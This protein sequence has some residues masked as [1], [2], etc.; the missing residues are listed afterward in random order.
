MRVGCTKVDVLRYEV[1][2]QDVP[3]CG[4]DVRRGRLRRCC[5]T[6]VWY[7]EERGKMGEVGGLNTH[8]CR[9][10][11]PSL[12]SPGVPKHQSCAARE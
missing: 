6:V 5:W 8:R 12:P 3:R 7:V 1:P 4:L 9:K 11:D 2:R 10:K